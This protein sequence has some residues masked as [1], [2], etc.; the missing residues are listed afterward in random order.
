MYRTIAGINASEGS[1]GYKSIFIKPRIGGGLNHASAALETYYGKL[2]SSWKLT[3]GKFSMEVTI[4]ANTT[5]TIYIPAP[6]AQAVTASGKALS[7]VK[8]VKITD[9]ND[10]AYVAVRVGSGSYQFSV[11]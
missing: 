4:P 2:S 8:D 10:K 5:A 11:N 3:A 9:T 6:N 7:T 1:V